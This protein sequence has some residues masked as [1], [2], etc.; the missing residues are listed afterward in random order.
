[1]R[2]VTSNHTKNSINNINGGPNQHNSYHGQQMDRLDVERM[3]NQ[4]TRGGFQDGP[5]RD[6]FPSR[7]SRS[8]RGSKNN[9]DNLGEITGEEIYDDYENYDQGMPLR[10]QYSVKKP[11][12]DS[13]MYVDFNIFDKGRKAPLANVSYYDP[14]S[15]APSG[16]A[17]ISTSMTKMSNQ[18]E[19]LSV[20]STGVESLCLHLYDMFSNTMHGNSFVINSIG[21]YGLFA[22]LYIASDGVTEQEL[23]QYFNF[24][25]H[26][27]IFN[28][29]LPLIDECNTIEKMLNI[30][31]IIIIGNTVPYS[32]HYADE[33]RDMC[34]LF[35]VNIKNQV[36]EADRVNT[37]VKKLMGITMRRSVVAEH[38]DK[39]QLMLLNLC[40]I[41]PIWNTP[42]DKVVK[43]S[44]YG[45]NGKRQENFL[46]SVGKSCGYY[47]DS[48]FQMIELKCHKNKMSMGIFLSKGDDDI[49]VDDSKLKFYVSH[50]KDVVLDEVKIPMFRHDIKTRLTDALQSTGLHSVFVK[51]V[52]PEFLPEHGT[53]HDVV[54]NTTIIIDNNASSTSENNRG[55]QTSRKFIANRQF[56]Y[57]FRLAM[58]NTI[59]VMGSYV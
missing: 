37:L 11:S 51:L 47:E 24:P 39:L 13:N 22:S 58:S 32:P 45:L 28:G 57:Y 25:T 34:I 43:N 7:S 49:K 3:F 15:S 54:Q 9:L 46:Y 59:I 52:M 23:V 18:L 48:T 10:A 53:L 56:T 6:M 44:F 55:Y 38:I 36:T 20:C 40:V 27:Y 1:M 2:R 16:F 17:D 33:I 30:K 5:Q 35:R 12:H 19:P 8:Y 26:N 21:L 42:F 4:D 50:L 29:L 31:N 41:R 14:S